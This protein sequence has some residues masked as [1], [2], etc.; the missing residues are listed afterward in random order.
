MKVRD[1]DEAVRLANDSQYG[2]SGSV[3]GRDR[4]RAER[5]ARRLEAGSCNVNDVL[6]NYLASDVPFGGWKESGIGTRHGAGGIKKFCRTESLVITR[7]AG[8]SEPLWFP[9]SPAKAR[10]LRA[11]QRFILR[12]GLRKRAGL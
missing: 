12:R 1:E 3:W 9:Y 11:I 7:L 4:E 2:L 6:V 5:I 10:I 8:K